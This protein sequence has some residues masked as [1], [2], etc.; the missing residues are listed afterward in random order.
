MTEPEPT[1][2]VDSAGE[3]TATGAEATP[4]SDAEASDE[5]A[6]DTAPQA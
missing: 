6:D 1:E 2:P 3:E 4:E 5:A